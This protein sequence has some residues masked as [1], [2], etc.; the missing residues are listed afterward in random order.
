MEENNFIK[1]ASLDFIREKIAEDI[2]NNKNSLLLT[3]FGANETA[4]RA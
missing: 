2:K 4:L 1:K 3:S